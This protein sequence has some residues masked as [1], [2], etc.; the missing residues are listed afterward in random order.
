MRKVYKGF[1]LYC[2]VLILLCILSIIGQPVAY[3]EPKAVVSPATLSI[4][5]GAKVIFRNTG[6]NTNVRYY[7][8]FGEQSG[9][10]SSF[11]P[12]TQN[13]KPGD[14][15]VLLTLTD[16]QK[17][18]SHA[19][20]TLTVKGAKA[21]KSSSMLDIMPAQVTVIAGDDIEFMNRYESQGKNLKYR[22]K[23]QKQHSSK[24][25]F[26]L[27]T[28]SLK[29]GRYVLV[30]SV[31]GPAGLSLTDSAVVNIVASNIRMPNLIGLSVTEALRILSEDKLKIGQ[32][33]QRRTTVKTAK[34]LRQSV[35]PG[36]MLGVGHT[37]NLVEAI[38][39]DAAANKVILRASSSRIA[40]GQTVKFHALLNP[41]PKSTNGYT[42]LFSINGKQKVSRTPSIQWKFDQ[43]GSYPVSV[44]IRSSLGAIGRSSTLRINVENSW[45][46][47][48]AKILPE[49]LVIQ[50]G[51]RAEFTSSSLY[52]YKGK[53]TYRWKSESGKKGKDRRFVF[54]TEQLIPKRYAI[55]L[56]IKD[57]K[58][59]RSSAK[60]VLVIRPPTEENSAKTKPIRKIAIAPSS[61]VTPAKEKA[62]KAEAPSDES[63]PK[64]VD[65]GVQAQLDN[66]QPVLRLEVSDQYAKAGEPITFTLHSDVAPVDAQYRFDFGSGKATDWQSSNQ[67]QFSYQAFGN[68]SVQASMRLGRKV[69]TAQ[70][71]YIW[72]WSIWFFALIA[73]LGAVLFSLV[74]WWTGRNVVQ[75]VK[76]LEHL[77]STKKQPWFTNMRD[78]FKQ[79][80]QKD[81]DWIPIGQL[82][83]YTIQFM[84][85]ILLTFIGLYYWLF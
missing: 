4:N 46:K 2:H 30:G 38:P 37:V 39:K 84:V 18:Q 82:F 72:V 63:Y 26:I 53:L 48:E 74:W 49:M 75:K 14:Y 11:Q 66:Q 6:S 79:T 28:K 73:M 47:P 19:Y 56:R 36:T 17:Q 54:E 55:T 71:E 7:W 69:H 61:S 41:K 35:K 40:R 64:M 8:Q 83:I 27:K 65:A 58:G 44:I 25:R 76:Q 1:S 80:K 22:W 85:A 13:L 24:P 43:L 5:A 21:D 10:Q 45:Q 42:Y 50:Q 57:S 78:R 77:S 23:F 68:Y 62:V 31:V 67:Q 52:D 60:A 81:D 12:S 9:H 51:D 15:R 70:S 33:D 59:L 34:V 3:A 20:A 29:P 32:I 16:S